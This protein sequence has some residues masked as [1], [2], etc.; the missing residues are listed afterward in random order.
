MSE[1]KKKERPYIRSSVRLSSVF[2]KPRY[3]IV[4]INRA[5]MRRQLTISLVNA[6]SLQ[7]AEREFLRESKTNN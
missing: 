7:A 5:G 1:S 6:S 3:R 4:K 2:G